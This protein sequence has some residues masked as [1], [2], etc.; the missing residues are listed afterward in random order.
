MWHLR[1]RAGLVPLGLAETEYSFMC[2]TAAGTTHR[3]GQGGLMKTRSLAPEA[4]FKIPQIP[5]MISTNGGPV[6]QTSTC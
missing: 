6:M 2:L 1:A 3:V 5:H 4:G